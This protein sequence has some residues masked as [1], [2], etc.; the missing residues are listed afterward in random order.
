MSECEFRLHQ[1]DTR[2]QHH[3]G[4]ER[5]EFVCKICGVGHR[6]EITALH[7]GKMQVDITIFPAT[8]PRKISREIV[9]WSM[10][11]SE[12]TIQQMQQEG[13]DVVR[14]PINIEGQPEGL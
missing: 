10:L 5:V 14:G 1:W 11:T 12:G 6:L 3:P 9:R 13:V 4:Y 8:G 2:E 7:Q